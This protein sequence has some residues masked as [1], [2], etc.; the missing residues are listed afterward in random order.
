MKSKIFDW[1]VLGTVCLFAFFVNNEIIVP[2]IMEARNIV[3]AREMVYEGHWVVP[4]MNGYIRLEKPPLP[5]WLTAFTEYLSPDNLFLQR[6][7]A[8]LAA[9]LLVIF[10]NYKK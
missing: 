5:T 3:T 1:S 9:C 7:V 4:T 6:A 8:G 2:D 10:K